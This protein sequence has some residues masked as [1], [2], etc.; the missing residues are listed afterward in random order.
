[1]PDSTRIIPGDS[2]HT[3][4]GP[5]SL[6]R[7]DSRFLNRFTCCHFPHCIFYFTQQSIKFREGNST[8]AIPVWFYFICGNVVL[9]ILAPHHTRS[10][11]HTS[12]LQSLRH[13]VCR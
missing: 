12:E 6:S 2:K 1:M 8:L 3:R 4:H 11:E 5:I 7:F 13:L 9:S 10:E